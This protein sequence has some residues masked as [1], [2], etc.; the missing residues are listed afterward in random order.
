MQHRQP[1]DSPQDIRA[2]RE[3]S[4]ND[5]V[6]IV[7]THHH[8]QVAGQEKE[9]PVIAWPRCHG[10][11]P[12]EEWQQHQVHQ[13][14]VQRDDCPFDEFVRLIICSHKIYC[15]LFSFYIFVQLEH[16]KHYVF[17]QLQ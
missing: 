7:F 9:I 8:R 11:V 4:V 3:A 1:N 17:M 6:E 15:G 16:K 2:C 12:D 13:D 14:E 5:G 10:R